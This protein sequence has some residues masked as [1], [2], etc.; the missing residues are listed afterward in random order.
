MPLQAVKF[1]TKVLAPVVISCVVASVAANVIGV[2]DCAAR[3]KVERTKLPWF[4]PSTANIFELPYRSLYFPKLY[5]P[6]PAHKARRYMTQVLAV[7]QTNTSSELL[8][9]CA[10]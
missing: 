8:D 7:R 5:L 4:P 1:T 2:V 9:F 10:V 3:L 6:M